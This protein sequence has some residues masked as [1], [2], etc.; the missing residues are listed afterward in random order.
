M[1][2]LLSS[3]DISGHAHRSLHVTMASVLQ[4]PAI[5]DSIAL[6]L[7]VITLFMFLSCV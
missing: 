4:R 3:D 7:S 2:P 1:P 5:Q 6:R